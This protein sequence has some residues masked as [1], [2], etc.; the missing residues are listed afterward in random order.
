MRVGLA[1]GRGG[2][3]GSDRGGGSTH[4]GIHIEHRLADLV[5]IDDLP[6]VV[7]P[8]RRG[9]VRQ[10][11][12]HLHAPDV[13]VDGVVAFW[14]AAGAAGGCELV[15]VVAGI[16]VLEVAL[17]GGAGRTTR[18]LCNLGGGAVS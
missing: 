6:V 8:V 10:V 14:I 9:V 3:D 18:T 7:R 16:L 2:G 13:V 17:A 12:G 11:L 15:V 5:G 4:L 1:S